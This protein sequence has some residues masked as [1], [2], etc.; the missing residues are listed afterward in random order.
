MKELTG[1]EETTARRLYEEQF[2]FIPEFTWWIATNH[3]PNVPGDDT[4]VW[5][6]I[7]FVP[8]EVRIP[9]DEED[10]DF[11]DKLR[12]EL[13]G[14][15]VWAVRGA[16]EW[17]EHGLGTPEEIIAATA[18]YRSDMDSFGAW[19]D[20]RCF[21]RP[22]VRTKSSTLHMDYCAWSTYRGETP[23]GIK[24]FSQ[25]MAERGFEKVRDNGMK[26]LGVGLRNGRTEPYGSDSQELS[27]EE[28]S[29]EK[30]G[31]NPSEPFRP[32]VEGDPS[33]R[34]RQIGGWS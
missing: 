21:F 19:L 31:E 33:V 7:R 16:L 18:S 20:E 3:R 23:V 25:R 17:R 12:A 26:W 4:A 10:P 5:D 14:V 11:G 1:N 6:R 34:E 32:S 29:R 9:D 2:A 15:L 30:K 8:F 13:S 22:D 24:R 28:A 27:H